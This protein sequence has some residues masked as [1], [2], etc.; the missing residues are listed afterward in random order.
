[1]RYANGSAF[2]RA[3]EDRLRAISLDDGIPLV[4][5]RKMVA[6]NRY[7]TR[8][9]AAFPGQWLLKGGF[10]LQLRLGQRSRTTKDIDLLMLDVQ[11]IQSVLLSAGQLDLGDWFEFEVEPV[12]VE[13]IRAF[14]GQRFQIQSRL[15]GRVF[16]LFHLDVGM[17]DPVIDPPVFLAM[18]NLLDFADIQPVSVPCYPLTQQIAEKIHAYTRPHPSGQSSRAK[19]FVDLLL[20]ISLEQIDGGQLTRALS[21]T[22][23][24]AQTHPLPDHLPSPPQEWQGYFQRAAK[25]LGL[26]D[27]SFTA[28]IEILSQ[29]ANPVLKQQVNVKIWH[30][31]QKKWSE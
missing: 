18:P 16:E 14:G 25:E 22:F 3:L 8:L 12:T 17:E 24:S 10:A 29:F 21:A 9:A 27:I 1:M 2:R 11:D 30:P 20:M 6:F 13:D 5:L 28:G 26:T 19:D 4:R 31:N 15:D 23:D 7:L